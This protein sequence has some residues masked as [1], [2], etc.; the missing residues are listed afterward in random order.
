[1]HSV[2]CSKRLFLQFSAHHISVDLCCFIRHA[3]GFCH[4]QVILA[5]SVLS[6]PSSG[7]RNLYPL[8]L[9]QLC[10]LQRGIS[11]QP[12]VSSFAKHI[13]LTFFLA[14]TLVPRPSI[15]QNRNIVVRGQ[16][17]FGVVFT[18]SGDVVTTAYERPGSYRR[19]VNFLSESFASLGKARSNSIFSLRQRRI[20][21]SSTPK[22]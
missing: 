19:R 4:L 3:G 6:A 7:F 15:W 21:V 14:I 20:V 18:P 11:R 2:F 5:A 12:C 17:I 10:S 8:S 16:H 9:K 22:R 1:M 13:T